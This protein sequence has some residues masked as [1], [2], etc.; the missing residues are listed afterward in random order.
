MLS[1]VQ[2]FKHFQAKIK[3]YNAALEMTSFK[4]TRDLTEPESIQTIQIECLICHQIDFYNVL[5]DMISF[6]CNLLTYSAYIYILL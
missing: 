1:T 2:Y 5:C 6:Y 3:E 4:A